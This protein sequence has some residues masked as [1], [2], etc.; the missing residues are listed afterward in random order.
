[1][2][3]LIFIA[4]LALPACQTAQPINKPCGAIRDA[5]IDVRGAT[6]IE[7]RRIDAHV[8]RGVAA[9]CWDRLGRLRS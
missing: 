3:A 2:R 6:A 4:L 7:T 5:L 9:G 8:E 1:M